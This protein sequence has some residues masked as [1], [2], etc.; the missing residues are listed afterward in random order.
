MRKV[1]IGLL[2]LCA[3]SV[4]QGAA[5]FPGWHDHQSASHYCPACNLNRMSAVSPSAIPSVAPV[6]WVVW[7]VVPS[8][9]P[10]ASGPALFHS[11]SRAPPA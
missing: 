6:L 4:C 9:T 7:N 1:L 11:Q 3:I 10:E 2:L 8:R 5:Y